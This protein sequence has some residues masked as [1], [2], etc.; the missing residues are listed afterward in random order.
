[1]RRSRVPRA[2]SECQIAAFPL[3][4]ACMRG[5]SRFT[6]CFVCLVAFLTVGGGARAQAQGGR[7]G[8]RRGEVTMRPGEACPPGTT[9]VRPGRCSAPESPPPSILDYRP[10][11]TL[12]TAEHL[13][14]KA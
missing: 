4:G 11:S 12:V 5:A 6:S 1:M 10:R 13:V 3:F 2:R 9:Q 8:G 14:K 7:P